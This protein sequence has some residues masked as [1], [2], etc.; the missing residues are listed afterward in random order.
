MLLIR[1]PYCEEHRSEEEFSYAGEAHLRRPPDPNAVSDEEWTE[2]LFFRK[3]PR[4]VHREMWCHAAGC[5]RYFNVVRNTVTYE[6]SQ[7]YR[8]GEQPAPNGGDDRQIEPSR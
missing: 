5:R 6:I 8:I 2:Y 7:T 4:G 1:C 3:N